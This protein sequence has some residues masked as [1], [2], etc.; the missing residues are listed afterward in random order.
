M[1]AWEGFLEARTGPR[2][3]ENIP[4]KSGLLCSVG[5]QGDHRL[6]QA[7]APTPTPSFPPCP[8]GRRGQCCSGRTCSGHGRSRPRGWIP[9]SASLHLKARSGLRPAQPSRP[10]L[11]SL[12]AFAQESSGSLSPPSLPHTHTHTPTVPLIGTRTHTYTYAQA[13]RRAPHVGLASWPLGHADGLGEPWARGGSLLPR[14]HLCHLCPVPPFTPTLGPRKAYPRPASSTPPPQPCAADSCTP[15]RHSGCVLSVYFHC[16]V[17]I[18]AASLWLEF[19]S[20]ERPSGRA[21]FRVPASPPCAV[22]SR[23]VLIGLFSYC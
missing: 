17:L 14:G 10:P 21:S 19:A 18:V 13:H 22:V 15:S 11:P 9:L 3:M 12:R 1:V 2:R 4:T 7:W 5:P 16:L 8:P 23:D 6:S 20:P